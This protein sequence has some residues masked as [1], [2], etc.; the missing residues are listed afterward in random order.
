MKYW[1]SLIF[2]F[3]S[4]HVS[5]N[6]D[7]CMCQENTADCKIGKLVC[8]GEITDGIS[9]ARF[10]E[11]QIFGPDDGFVPAASIRIRDFSSAPEVSDLSFYTTSCNGLTGSL[12]TGFLLWKNDPPDYPVLGNKTATLA[13]EWE[14]AIPFDLKINQHHVTG[15]CDLEKP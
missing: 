12:K 11:S 4:L 6:L 10:S 7:D 5:A 13:I 8:S 15:R 9:T 1:I 2:I 14:K 3:S